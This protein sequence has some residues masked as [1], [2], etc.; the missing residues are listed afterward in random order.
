MKF[1]KKHKK[2]ILH[3]IITGVILAVGTVLLATIENLIKVGTALFTLRTLKLDLVMA[4]YCFVAGF[5]I[6]ILISP[7]VNAFKDIKN[8]LNKNKK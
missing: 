6:Y 1:F 7:I 8:E 5:T 2:T 4:A 3:A